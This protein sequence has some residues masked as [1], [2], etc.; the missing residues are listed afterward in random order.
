MAFIAADLVELASRNNFSDLADQIADVVVDWN[1]NYSY[2]NLT[3]G[4]TTKKVGNCQDF[5]EVMLTALGIKF[6]F[7]N[8]A[9]GEF[10]KDMREKGK[11]DMNFKPSAAFRNKFELN[12]KS[13]EFKAHKEFDVF[14]ASLMENCDNF[15]SVFK[16]EYV[17]LKSFDRAF[18]LRH[19]KKPHIEEYK[20][21]HEEEEEEE[22]E[23]EDDD[24]DN[25]NGENEDDDDDDDDD[26]YDKWCK[27]PFGDPRTT[28]SVVV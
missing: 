24:D 3:I 11:S 23:E 22:G 6:D 14:V 20:P 19:I 2:K 4:E 12:E 1:V 16:D 5:V 18:W 15:S 28:G 26:D 13:F 25:D 7:Q 17:L 27:C 8:G 10:L 21:W 9:L